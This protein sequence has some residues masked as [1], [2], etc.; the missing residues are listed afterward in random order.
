[1]DILAQLDIYINQ[2]AF[3]I[4][5]GFGGF[6]HY[7][8]KYLKKETMVPFYDWFGKSNLPA[9]LYTMIVFT[10]AIIGAHAGDGSPASNAILE[11]VESTQ[12]V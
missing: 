4:A 3:I 5:A 8:K 2:I 10:F 6:A 9:T 7:L 12:A 11:L 1:M